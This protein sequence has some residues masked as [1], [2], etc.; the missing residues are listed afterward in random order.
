MG[1]GCTL[2]LTAQVKTTIAT[3]EADWIGRLLLSPNPTSGVT[4]LE[5]QLLQAEALRLRVH[6]AAGRLV[7]EMTPDAVV[8]V[9]QTIDLHRYAAGVYQLSI[10]SRDRVATRKL[11]LIK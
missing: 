1:T 2:A 9:T 6:D 7:W 8:S 3:N 4:L 5:I 11:V 10:Q